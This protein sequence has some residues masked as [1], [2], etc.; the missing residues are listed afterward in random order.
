MPL[1][2]RPR[3]SPD[4]VLTKVKQ[5]NGHMQKEMARTSARVS[6]VIS[7]ALVKCSRYAYCVIFSVP[8][9]RAVPKGDSRPTVVILLQFL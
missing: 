7:S 1:V 9:E 8:A 6:M 5:Q 2:I 4:I 3:R